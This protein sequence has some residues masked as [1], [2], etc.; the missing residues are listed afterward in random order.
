MSPFKGNFLRYENSEAQVGLKISSRLGWIAA[1]LTFA[2]RFGP[3][4]KKHLKD[5]FGVSGPTVSRDQAAMLGRLSAVE[6]EAIRVQGGKIETL[7]PCAL[8]DFADLDVPTVDEWLKVMLGPRHVVITRPERAT[9]NPA[10][11][12]AMVRCMEDHR[13]IFVLYVSQ[14]ASEPMWR[15][16][17]PHS[18]V[19]IAGRYHMRCYDHLRGRYGDFVLARMMDATFHRSDTPPYKDGR[20]DKEWSQFVAVKISLISPESP[21]IGKLDYGLDQ[22]GFR[23]IRLR[24][25]LAPYIIDKRMAGFEDQILIEIAE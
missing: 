3:K 20:D 13:A 25:A 5:H 10:I 18:I 22:E 4:E 17:S 23:I 9:P 16:V 24:K 12:W 11:I 14:S 6:G 15:A 1:C 2:G 21:L 7:D 8:P 19:N